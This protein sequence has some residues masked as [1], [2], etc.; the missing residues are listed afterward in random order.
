MTKKKLT[1][2]QDQATCSNN[3]NEEEFSSII[4]KER[5]DVARRMNAKALSTLKQRTKKE[6]AA[7]SLFKENDAFVQRNNLKYRINQ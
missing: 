5:C 1:P 4:T 6:N 2:H 7:L 3:V